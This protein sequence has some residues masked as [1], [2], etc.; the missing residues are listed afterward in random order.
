VFVV[1]CAVAEVVRRDAAKRRLLRWADRGA[2]AGIVRE[3]YQT[4]E[5]RI[6][7]VEGAHQFLLYILRL[8]T[9]YS[10]DSCFRSASLNRRQT[11]V[12]LACFISRQRDAW[13]SIALLGFIRRQ[14]QT[15]CYSVQVL[16]EPCGWHAMHSFLRDLG[17]LGQ[18][19]KI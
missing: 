2:M 19:G 15:S 7:Y 1:F 18:S 17:H 5:V 10:L 14:S 13:P 6:V 12:S 3:N 4:P 8:T 16:L 11:V 9:L